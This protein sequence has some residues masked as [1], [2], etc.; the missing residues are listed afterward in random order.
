VGATAAEKDFLSHQKENNH[1]AHHHETNPQR[2]L[3]FAVS[4][5]L[6]VVLTTTPKLKRGVPTVH[7]QSGCTDATLKGNYGVSWQGFDIVKGAAHEVPWAGVGVVGFDGAGNVS[8]SF[9]QALNGKITTGATGA[10]TYT[11]NSDCTGSPS[12]TSGDAAGES[13]IMV[14]VGGGTEVLFIST[15]SGQ[16]IVLDAKKQ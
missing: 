13:P 8:V 12:F 14:I 1:E 9:T 4:A 16:T 7:A 11:V 10:G 2:F 3:V 5:T 15:L 6:V